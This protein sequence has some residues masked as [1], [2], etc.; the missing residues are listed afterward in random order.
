M[1]SDEINDM[2][3]HL[4]CLQYPLELW[5]L[6][7]HCDEIIVG[8]VGDGQITPRFVIKLQIRVF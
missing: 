7:M 3:A 6:L 2:N 5:V 1:R 4:K 8:P